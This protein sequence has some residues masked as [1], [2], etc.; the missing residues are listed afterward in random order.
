M[1]RK[2]VASVAAIGWDSHRRFS[3]VTA[4]DANSKVLFRRRIEHT[5]REKMREILRSW[6][7]G[8]PVVLESTFGWS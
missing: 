6:P 4:R 1:D 7:A 5:E 8:T 2:R 3:Q